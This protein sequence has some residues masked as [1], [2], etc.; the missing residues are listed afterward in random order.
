M[1]FTSFPSKFWEFL[2]SF[3]GGVSSTTMID[4]EFHLRANNGGLGV[5]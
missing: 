2:R 3:V 4:C 1:I 5:E